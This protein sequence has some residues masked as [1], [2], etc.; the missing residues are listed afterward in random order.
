MCHDQQTFE[1]HMI[2]KLLFYIITL[3]L[4]AFTYI[5]FLYAYLE[6]YPSALKL[7]FAYFANFSA[8]CFQAQLVIRNLLDLK[9][10]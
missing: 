7:F 5:I 4:C 10:H 9:M 1:E 2:E 3:V 8:L 6:K